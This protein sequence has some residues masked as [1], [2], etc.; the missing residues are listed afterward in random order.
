MRHIS[1]PYGLRRQKIAA[2]YR[3]KVVSVLLLC[4]TMPKNERKGESEMLNEMLKKKSS[5]ARIG[6]IFRFRFGPDF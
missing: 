2:K 6:C 1:R 5:F 3:K 4:Y